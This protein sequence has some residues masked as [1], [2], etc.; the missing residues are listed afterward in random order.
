MKSQKFSL[1]I[2]CGKFFE[3]TCISR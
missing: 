3:I 1:F 2:F